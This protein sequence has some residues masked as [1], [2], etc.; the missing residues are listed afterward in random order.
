MAS[1]A[2]VV[3]FDIRQGNVLA[4]VEPASAAE[5]CDGVEFKAMTSGGDGVATDVVRFSHGGLFG[6]ACFSRLMTGNSEE[7]GVRMCSAGVLAASHG[8]LDAWAAALAAEAAAQ[9]A[10][11]LDDGA[12]GARLAALLPRPAGG[13]PPAPPLSRLVRELGPSVFVLWKVVMLQRR[14]LFSATAPVSARCDDVRSAAAFVGS[15][16]QLRTN[17]LFHVGLHDMAALSSLPSY[18]ACTSESIL[19]EKR[20]VFDVLVNG[21]ALELGDLASLRVTAADSARHA[22]FA[23]KSDAEFV[24]YFQGLSADVA[25][26][27]VAL[28]EASGGSGSELAATAEAAALEGLGLHSRDAEFAELLASALGFA[29][30]VKK[31]AV[32]PCC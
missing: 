22:A 12:A 5:L 23:G 16:A 21:A 20:Q 10:A 6:L 11:P 1:A 14:V 17:P 7:R 24:A 2:F 25:Q 15:H 13:A 19:L 4:A 27:L 9:N 29:L 28:C 8:E 18:I 26:G 32:A 30:R 31:S 3:R